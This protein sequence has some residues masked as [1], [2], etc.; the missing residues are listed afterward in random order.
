MDRLA[1]PCESRDLSFLFT[2]AYPALRLIKHVL[3]EEKIQGR[4]GLSILMEKRQKA[5]I[6]HDTNQIN[7]TGK[8]YPGQ[9]RRECYCFTPEMFSSRVQ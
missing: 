7:D 5:D 2:V 8:V 4:Q 9:E 1:F 3:N 6:T